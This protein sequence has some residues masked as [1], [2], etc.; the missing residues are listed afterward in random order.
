MRYPA[1]NIERVMSMKVRKIRLLRHM[2]GITCKEIGVAA[3]ISE[4]R[5]SQIE[6]CE[7]GITEATMIKLKKGLEK[8]ILNR[9]ESCEALSDA[10]ALHK[11]SL[12]EL[13]MENAY[14]L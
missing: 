7:E 12:F 14:E 8:I 10:Y 3:G 2:F 9:K 4:Q 5:V 13:V 11:D 6:L 1:L